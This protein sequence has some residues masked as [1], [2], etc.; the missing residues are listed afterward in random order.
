MS[1]DT[2][3]K[4][5]LEYLL[6]KLKTD[7]LDNKVDAEA[8]KGLSSNDYTTAE[9]NKLAGIAAN[10]EVNQNAFSNVKVGSTT[11]A[12]GEKTATLELEA[13]SNITLTPDTANK[14]VVLAA[15]DTTYSDA[16]TSVHGLMSVADK[17]KLDGISTGA[18]KVE[19]SETNGNIKI[20]GTETQVY[21]DSEINRKLSTDTSTVEGNPLNFNTLS[22]QNAKSTIL[23][24]EPI[25]DLHGYDKPWVGGAGI[26]KF[27]YS[28]QSIIMSNM[29]NSN[30]TFTNT[31]TDSKEF[32]P[33]IVLYNGSEFVK[34]V[35]TYTKT[36][37]RYIFTVSIAALYTII[38]IKHNGQTRDIA[39]RYP[40]STQGTLTISYYADSIDTTT[41]G[42]LVIKNIQIEISD[43]IHDY[44]PYTNICPISGRSEIG[45][46]GTNGKESTDPDYEVSNDL[47]I[48]LGQTVYGGTLDVENGVL[49]VDRSKIKINTLSWSYDSAPKNWFYSESI[50]NIKPAPNSA[51]PANTIFTCYK[52]VSRD[53]IYNNQTI[54]GLAAANPTK[55]VMIRD[56]ACNGD[57]TTFINTRG[58]E[59]ICYELVTP[60]TINLTSHTINLL[61]GV[62]NISTDGDSITLTY[63]DGSV[64]T[65]GDLTS[66]VDELDGKIEDSKILTDTATGDKY[67]LVVTN[68]TLSIEQI[69]N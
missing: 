57:T 20:N 39:I 11:I 41:I 43:T 18:N 10:A 53:Y 34:A 7:V 19:S 42:G 12:S 63:R 23:S 64:A 50:P 16:T 6:S 67:R 66:A 4:D 37:N 9:K 15:T 27:D 45:I 24:L 35:D 1:W 32:S 25:Q 13:G 22:A 52:N 69:S 62:N 68:G 21:D 33:R 54:D 38:E 14:K 29:T 51:T 26:N 17:T 2:L 60:I 30:G 61:K 40:F 59:E 58:N 5:N 55:I 8:G 28:N 56:I 3:P 47:T 65:L 46:L 31:N 44:A 36:G 49:V 48:S